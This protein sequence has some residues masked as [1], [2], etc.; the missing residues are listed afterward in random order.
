MTVSID[1]T[2]IG[3]AIEIAMI[4]GGIVAM[5]VGALVLYL[6]VRPPRHVRKQRGQARELDEA[7]AEAMIDLVD[8]MEARLEVL[9]RA[10]ADRERPRAIRADSNEKLL[11]S[12][13]E[14]RDTG[15]K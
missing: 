5:L 13:D 4:V 9:E 12:A 14:A 6:L 15:R 3:Q 8:R 11:Q 2:D 7:E 10:L 1:G